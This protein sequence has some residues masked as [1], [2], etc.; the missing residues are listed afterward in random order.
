MAEIEE[1][2]RDRTD[3][4]GLRDRTDDADALT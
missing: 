3:E 1:G 2:L 4:A